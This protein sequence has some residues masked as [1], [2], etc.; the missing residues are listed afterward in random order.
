[1][2][3]AIVSIGPINPTVQA[4]GDLTIFTGIVQ[5]VFRGAP[6]DITRDTLSFLLRDPN[7]EL[8]ELR[9]GIDQ[10]RRA[11]ATVSL[12]SFAYDGNVNDALWAVD[13]ASVDLANLDRGT[14]T[15]NV[16]VTAAL[17]VRGVNDIVLRVNYSVFV[18]TTPGAIV[19][20]D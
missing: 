7:E 11:S 5:C 8:A 17:A 3:I 15:A 10:F 19:I 12:A 14:G 18:N 13:S 2:S 1:M 4:A 6:S 9:I 16:Q 20:L